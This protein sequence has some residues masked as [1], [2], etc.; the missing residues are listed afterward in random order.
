MRIYPLKFKPI[1]KRCI[2]GGQKLR[3][4][5]NKD[6]PPFEKI[7]ES[8]ELV[9]LPN[10]KSIIDN[11]EFAGQTFGSIFQKYKKEIIGSENFPGDFPLLLKFLDA[12]DIL[13]VQVHPDRQTCLRLGKGQPK[14]E[15]WYIVD[16]LPGS[17]IYRGLKKGVTKTQFITAIQEGKVADLL[18]KIP[19]QAGQC[20]FLPAGT[21]HSTGAGILVAEVET[22]SDTTY[23]VFDWNRLDDLGKPRQLHIDE[24]IES[25]HFNDLSDDLAPKSIGRLVDSS[26][27]KIDKGHQAKNCE[28]LLMPGLM[29]ILVIL[30]GYGKILNESQSCINLHAGDT[31]LIP[32]AYKGAMQ[33]ADDTEYLIVTL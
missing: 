17:V 29:K 31:L 27:F 3:Q 8:W 28:V 32:A 2:W 14:T 18:I 21:V 26:F 19:V 23:R 10:D 1:Y 11:G 24:A 5:F 16:A 13:S 33:L 6:I 4:F 30:S 7:G 20:Y 12:Q 25:I 22:P 15:C 9:D